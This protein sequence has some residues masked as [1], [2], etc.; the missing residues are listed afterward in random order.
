MRESQ[1]DSFGC[2]GAQFYTEA[3][4]FLSSN[5]DGERVLVI[6]LSGKRSAARIAVCYQGWVAEVGPHPGLS[7]VIKFCSGTN[8]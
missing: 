8:F 4:Y 2:D 1:C 7:Y 5:S 3:S 6:V